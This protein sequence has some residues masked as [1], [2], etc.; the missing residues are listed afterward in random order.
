MRNTAR[1]IA[2]K[3]GNRVRRLRDA[4]GFS[5]E[6]LAETSGVH[7]AL[8]AAIEDGKVDPTFETLYFLGLGL[9][10]TMATLLRG[11]A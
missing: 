6:E 8:V 2:K 10:V 5:Q 11:V 1:S 9:R 7:R 3:F 4:R